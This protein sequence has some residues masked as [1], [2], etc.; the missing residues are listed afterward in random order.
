MREHVLFALL[1]VGYLSQNY[2]F[3]LHQFL[4]ELNFL[5]GWTVHC[6]GGGGTWENGADKRGRLKSHAI[7][8]FVQNLRQF[9]LWVKS[10]M[11]KV[12]NHKDKPHMAKP[13]FFIEAHA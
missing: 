5:K 8:N 10:H 7:A 9:I 11:S 4:S 3:Q 13:C 1:D 2:Y 6:S 12:Y